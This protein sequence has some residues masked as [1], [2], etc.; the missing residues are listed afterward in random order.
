M[1]TGPP[2]LRGGPLPA[3]PRRSWRLGASDS[4]LSREAARCCLVAEDEGRT[5]GGCV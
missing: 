3:Q 4:A 5:A 1:L 2:A